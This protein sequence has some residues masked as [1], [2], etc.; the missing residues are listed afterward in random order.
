VSDAL[1]DAWLAEMWR[2]VPE[3]H[4]FSAERGTRSKA[5]G[6]PRPR[7]KCPVCGVSY[8]RDYLPDHVRRIH[9]QTGAEAV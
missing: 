5:V 6:S 2:V 4:E 3:H 8:S 9:S 7:E 1:R